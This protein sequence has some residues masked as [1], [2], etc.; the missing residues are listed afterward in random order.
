[1]PA[2]TIRAGL[3]VR[4]HRHRID[5]GQAFLRECERVVRRFFR[6]QNLA[7]ELILCLP[8]VKEVS[9]LGSDNSAPAIPHDDEDAVT[10]EATLETTVEF[11]SAVLLVES[12][13]AVDFF[14][15]GESPITSSLSDAI[16]QCM[17]LQ[18]EEREAEC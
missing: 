18:E 2:S 4:P 14:G 17:A 1:M 15:S 8:V 6:L 12:F 9:G 3:F 5:V 13:A 16:E 10:G 11:E 7:P